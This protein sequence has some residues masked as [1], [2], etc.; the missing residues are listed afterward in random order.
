[1]S[2]VYLFSVK[3]STPPSMTIDSGEEVD[4]DVEGAFVDVEDIRDIPTPFT[5]E[6]EGHPL[7]PITGPIAIRGAEPGDSVTIELLDITPYGTGA[8][9]ILRN[10]G[11]LHDEFADPAMI[12]C[13]VRDGNAWFGDRIPIPLC[14]NLGTLSTMPSEG[15][16][17]SYAGP[18]G[19]DFD[20]RD[21]GIGSRV[22][23][24]VMV[25]EALVFMADP[26]AVISDGII[27]GTGVECSAKVRARLSL[28]KH[29]SVSRPI[30]EHRDTIQIIGT[31]DTVEAATQ[32]AS[33]AAVDFVAD[34]TE[35]S[36]QE[37]Y[38]LLGIVG[39]LRI[40]TSPRPIMA[41]R[42]IINCDVLTSAGW[43]GEV[44]PTVA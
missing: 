16:R 13:P 6:S 12:S 43:D 41:A 19:G 5:P 34:H 24:P 44:F 40:G 39:D 8:N 11:V 32:D 18:Y 20:Q 27:S 38:M 14:P 15:Y 29:H 23:L 26:H 1:M 42:L 4:V 35:L 7:A 36:R 2:K 21:V 3:P 33:R 30:I 25:P 31:G 17:P 37:A 9:A 28:V 22:H 10:F